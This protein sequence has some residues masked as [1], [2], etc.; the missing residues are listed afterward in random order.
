MG[1][2]K[3]EKNI[4]V[5]TAEEVR[6]IETDTGEKWA[7]VDDLILVLSFSKEMFNKEIKENTPSDIYADEEDDDEGVASEIYNTIMDDLIETLE[8]M[9]S[10]NGFGG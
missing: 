5:P 10:N 4:D 2:K 7:S 3:K 9:N 8:D 1:R 6:V